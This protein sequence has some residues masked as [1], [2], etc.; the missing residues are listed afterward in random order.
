M[1]VVYQ[2]S[3]C[4]MKSHAHYFSVKVKQVLSIKLVRQNPFLMEHGTN[5]HSVHAHVLV[6]GNGRMEPEMDSQK[7]TY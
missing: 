2:K 4:M 3:W 7:H 6:T 5:K 1:K